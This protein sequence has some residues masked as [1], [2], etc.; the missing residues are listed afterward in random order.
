MEF[1]NEGAE[2]KIF[3]IDNYTLKKIRLPKSYRIE[4]LDTKLRKK[5]NKR[6]FKVLTKLHENKLNVPKPMEL[7]EKKG[8]ELS[9]T[10]QYLQGD[11]LKNSINEKS[12]TKAFN[13]IIKMH[14]LDVTHGDLTTLNMIEEDSKVYLIDF[15][16]SEFSHRMEDKAVDL[17]LFF[18]C[19]KNEHHELYKQK[20]KLEQTYLKKATNG[21]LTIERLRKVELRGRNK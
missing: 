11:V 6:E 15:G 18:T 5:R 1:I 20:E 17:N 14:N 16:L 4:L 7:I 21:E 9:F 19:I 13:Q 10:F 3:K 8:E 2:A 12:L